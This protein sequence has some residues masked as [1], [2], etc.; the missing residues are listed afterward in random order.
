VVL[1]LD[2]SGDYQWHTFYGSAKSADEAHTAV[3]GSDGFVLAGASFLPWKGPANE[4]PLSAHTERGG[5]D[6]VVIKLGV[7]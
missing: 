4:E 7:E 2:S 3:M 5:C 6:I 1:K